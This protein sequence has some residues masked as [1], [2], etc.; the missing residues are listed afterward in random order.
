MHMP[1]TSSCRR[2]VYA[3]DMHM[4]TTR[5]FRRH[6]CTF[7]RHVHADDMF[8]QT[9]CSCIRHIHSDEMFMQTTCSRR[10]HVHADDMQ[11]TQHDIYATTDFRQVTLVSCEF[12]SASQTSISDPTLIGKWCDSKKT[13][14]RSYEDI[15]IVYN[16]LLVFK[17]I[18][19]LPYIF[20]LQY[21]HLTPLIQLLS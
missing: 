12:T 2:H 15:I 14:I 4:Q 8:M 18:S 6:H 3:D 1:T 20:D 21:Q 13:C 17:V 10:R 16:K 9:T 19:I 11:H 7:R 5:I